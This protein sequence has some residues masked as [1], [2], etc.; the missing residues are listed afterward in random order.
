MNVRS[1]LRLRFLVLL[2]MAGVMILLI[3]AV[4]RSAPTTADAPLLRYPVTAPTPKLGQPPAIAAPALASGE[5]TLFSPTDLLAGWQVVDTPPALPGEAGRWILQDGLLVQDGIGL[6]ASL[7]AAYT[8][9]LSPDAYQDVT[10]TTTFADTRNGA[11]GLIARSST[12]GAYRV[13]LHADPSYDGEA[14]VLEKVIDGVGVPLVLN[15][16]EPLYRPRTWHTLSLSV[17]GETLRVTLD[18]QLVAQAVDAA[19]L[20]AGQVGLVARALGGI[21]FS[22]VAIQE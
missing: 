1:L 8:A 2:L 13:R 5:T 12:A 9:L 20:P 19:P 21:A 14:L 18:G 11:F 16:G 15:T 22:Q 6:A 10:I 3:T 4:A 17:V 7:S